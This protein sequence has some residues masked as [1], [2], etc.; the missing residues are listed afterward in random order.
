[1][2]RWGFVAAPGQRKKSSLA[3]WLAGFLVGRKGGFGGLDELLGAFDE[4]A[5][6]LLVLFVGAGVHV[7]R[8]SFDNRLIGGCLLV[9]NLGLLVERAAFGDGVGNLGG[10]EADGAQGVIVAGD[11]PVHHVG[12]AVGV[13]DG[14]DGDAHAAGFLDGDLFG[15]RIDDE[16]GVRQLGHVL[17]ALQVLLQVLHLTV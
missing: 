12:I 17:D 7:V 11:D 1:M 8:A 15:V 9:G 14:D 10:E 4:I 16:H 2:A 3:P 5:F 13:H 6:L